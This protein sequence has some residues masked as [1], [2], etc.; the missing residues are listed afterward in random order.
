[1]M[2]CV[3]DQPEHIEPPTS[4]EDVGTEVVSSDHPGT[5]PT[6]KSL[7]RELSQVDQAVYRAV[8]STPTPSLDV[9]L[10]R[11]SNSANYSVVWVG[12]AGA[13]VIL[14]GPR[15]RRA[16]VAGLTSILASSAVVNL[17]LKNLHERERPDRIAA[18][19]ISSRHTRMPKSPSFPS[20]H[21]A[22]GFAFA[23]AVGCQ[24]PP[25]S[26]PLRVVAAAVAYSRVHSGV[27]Y[28]GDVIV[29]SVVG[30]GIGL[31]VGARFGRA[32]GST[33]AS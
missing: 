13:L 11:L 28:P 21:S 10:R 32:S 17:A 5:T 26:F 33:R 8:A 31:M 30:G 19:M 24:I 4:V 14:G 23:T 1:M 6:L 20:G 2:A 3:D 22:S 25:L 12:A 16:A 29:G 18:G 15:G 27:H 7:L 9:P